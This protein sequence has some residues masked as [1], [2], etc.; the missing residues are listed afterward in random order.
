MQ[1]FHGLI[2]RPSMDPEEGGALEAARVPLVQDDPQ[3]PGSP[4]S[5]LLTTTSPAEDELYRT[6]SATEVLRDLG[7]VFRD[8]YEF[9]RSADAEA[10]AAAN[11]FY[12]CSAVH[13]AGS[14]A[15]F[16]SHSWADGALLK[17]LALRRRTF[18]S[19]GTVFWFG[20]PTPCRASSPNIQAAGFVT[21]LSCGAMSGRRA[22]SLGSTCSS[23]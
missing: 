1:R 14:P 4:F 12:G 9:L 3:S 15:A 7:G 19:L 5:S 22:A 20:R 23:P 13:A 6:A 8:Q 18:G 11:R 16:L 10:E 21:G 2:T 17:Y